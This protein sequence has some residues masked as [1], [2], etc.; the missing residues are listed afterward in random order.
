MGESDRK[1]RPPYAEIT[2]DYTGAIMANPLTNKVFLVINHYYEDNGD[3]DDLDLET[4]D[5]FPNGMVPPGRSGKRRPVERVRLGQGRLVDSS[6]QVPR[7]RGSPKTFETNP[8]R[9]T[10]APSGSR[11]CQSSVASGA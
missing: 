11:H 1:S 2:Q 7:T 3:D 8:R 6:H 5:G 4:P 10:F 9:Q